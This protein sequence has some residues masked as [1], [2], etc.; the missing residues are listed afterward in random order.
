M[1]ARQTSSRSGSGTAE[2][3]ADDEPLPVGRSA[4]LERGEQLDRYVVLDRLGAGAMGLV[5]AAYDPKLDRRVALKLLHGRAGPEVGSRRG[6]RLL[7]EA[8]A[9]AQ[10]THPNVVT[11][12]DVGTADDRVFLAM[13]YVKGRTLTQWLADEPGWREVLDV[14]IAAGRGLVAAHAKGLVHRD[15][16]PDNVMIGDDGRVRVMDF[17]LARA[18]DDSLSSSSGAM[19]DPPMQ[20]THTGAVMGTPA[21]MAPEQHLGRA[22]DA[23]SDQFAF[24]VA[25]YEGLYGERPF[26]GH[27]PMALGVA[28]TKGLLR[29]APAGRS[30]PKWLRRVVL[31]G[32]R[33]EPHDRFTDMSQLLHVL[34]D[35]PMRRRRRHLAWAGGGGLLLAGGL[36]WGLSPSPDAGLAPCRDTAAHLDGRW[37]D[38]RV[39]RVTQAFT[40]SGS[41]MATD[42]WVRVH[43]R[44]DRYTDAWVRMRTDNCRATRVHGDQSEELLDLRNACLDRRLRQVEDVVT[45]LEQADAEVVQRAVTLV[46]A[47]PSLDACADVVALRQGLPPPGDAAVAEQVERVREGIGRAEALSHAGRYD[48]ATA[49]ATELREQAIPLDY[50]PVLAETDMLAG[51]LRI[52]IGESA[53]AER[54]L[55]R[56]F[57]CALRVRHDALAARAAARLVYVVGYQL[58][59]QADGAAWGQHALSL[60]LRVG[61][62]QLAEAE[63]HHSL[64]VLADAGGDDAAAR[65]HHQR[66]YELRTRLL[67]PDHPDLA[68]SLNALGNVHLDRGEYDDALG[69]Y[70]EALELRE[71]VFGPGHPVVA[72]TLNNVSITLRRKGDFDGAVEALERAVRIYEASSSTDHP[73]LARA[74]N[75]LGLVLRDGGD[76]IAAEAQHRRALELRER[77]LD[78]EH[79]DLGDS[80]TGL[81]RA[82]SDQGR[83]DEAEPLLER[84]LQMYERSFGPEHPA[85]A[86]ALVGIGIS[87]HGQGRMQ[88]AR[89]SVERA[90][91]I[92]DVRTPDTAEAREARVWLERIRAADGSL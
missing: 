75:N 91:A 34:Q 66:A 38:A 40:E 92:F 77:M 43:E 3:L 36:A 69:R 64:G 76:P 67:P 22:V 8:Q 59:R 49:L 45:M 28:V 60:G 14:F 83:H 46:A 25:L 65:E 9:M 33:T 57:F 15:F 27:T 51:E 1:D 13:E 41:A 18:G 61:E 70:R 5:Y 74:F 48:E 29:E 16:K 12:H 50:P 87:R 23:R 10:L 54:F 24:C 62:G 73:A 42:T 63:V 86:D 21:Y 53:E 47:L 37:D 71:K 7:R 17:G 82:L 2:T 44:L 4:G 19:I 89:Q 84:A 72:G 20:V 32:L 52:E 26:A 85:V 55:Q 31:R 90:V 39:Q 68:R 56:A 58:A 79:P 81:A 88:S 80:L 11:V 6:Q 30:I 78:P 35:D